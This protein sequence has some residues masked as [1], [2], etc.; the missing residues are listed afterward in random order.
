ME[1]RPS[2]TRVFISY[3]H[4]DIVYREA[5]VGNHQDKQL[6]PSELRQDGNLMRRSG[7][8]LEV[9]EKQER[10]VQLP[11]RAGEFLLSCKYNSLD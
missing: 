1:T 2:W 3:S 10:I 6:V 8:R 7:Q 9:K 11:P 4:R 5:L